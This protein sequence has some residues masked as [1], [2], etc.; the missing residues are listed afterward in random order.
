MVHHLQPVLHPDTRGCLMLDG[1]K[2]QSE[3]TYGQMGVTSQQPGNKVNETDRQTDR[4]TDRDVRIST[5]CVGG[6]VT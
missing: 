4:Q 2:G 1:V 5:H 6:A 3:Q